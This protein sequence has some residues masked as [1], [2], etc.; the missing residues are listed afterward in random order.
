MSAYRA[1]VA[2]DNRNFGVA[3]DDVARVVASL[4]GVDATAAGVD[5]ASLAAV[6]SEAA[7]VRISVATNLQSQRA[8]LLRLADDLSALSG[9][10]PARQNSAHG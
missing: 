6:K 2:L 1:A 3:N 7:G 10:S 9:K 8:Q 5:N 4:N